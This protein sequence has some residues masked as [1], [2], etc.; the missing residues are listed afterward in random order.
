VNSQASNINSN[1]EQA[2]YHVRKDDK[3]RKLWVDMICINQADVQE[4]SQEIPKMR[5]IYRRADRVLIWVGSY[6]DLRQ[7]D[8]DEAFF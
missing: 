5:D 7:E 4:K 8:V 1:L 3:V 6:E 2:L